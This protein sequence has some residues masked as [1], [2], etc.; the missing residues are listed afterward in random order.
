MNTP[1]TE[2]VKM[3]FKYIK[4]RN[5]DLVHNRKTKGVMNDTTTM[6]HQRD[7]SVEVNEY[8]KNLKLYSNRMGNVKK[9]KTKIFTYPNEPYE[10]FDYT[11]EKTIV[12]RVQNTWHNLFVSC[13]Y[14]ESE[15]F[16]NIEAEYALMRR[17]DP[18]TINA[19]A[20]T[21][22]LIRQEFIEFSIT[23][24]SENSRLTSDAKELLTGLLNPS[25]V[26]L[27]K[28]AVGVFRPKLSI[29]AG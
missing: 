7:A 24:R 3:R 2:D 15:N 22:N 12:T 11:D 18:Y 21:T 5:I 17:A 25:T 6:L 26:N 8:K 9:S 13:E 19:K 10:L 28:V 1:D 27:E 20:V 4:Q 14:E 29:V 16:S 23:T